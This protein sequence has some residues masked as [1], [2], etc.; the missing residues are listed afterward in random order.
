MTQAL[1]QAHEFDVCLRIRHVVAVTSLSKSE[2]N[3]FVSAIQL[4]N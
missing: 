3:A 1:A 2:I 4:E